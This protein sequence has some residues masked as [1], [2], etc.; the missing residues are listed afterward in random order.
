MTDRSI[1]QA[2]LTDEGGSEEEQQLARTLIDAATGPV[3]WA[4]YGDDT[5]ERLSALVEAKIQRRQVVVVADE[6]PVKTLRLLDA[7]KQSVAEATGAGRSH[8]PTQRKRRFL[9]GRSSA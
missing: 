2:E 9:F 1:A 8:R 5:A 7:L 4:R 6:E 3:D